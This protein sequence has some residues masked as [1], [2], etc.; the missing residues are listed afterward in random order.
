M[1]LLWTLGYMLSFRISAFVF[2]YIYP[3]MELLGNIVFQFL[4]FWEA[5]ILFSITAALIYNPTNSVW[6][7]PFLQILVNSCYLCS[8]WWYAFWQV[9]GDISLWFWFAFPWWLA[10]LSII[11]C[12]I[13]MLSFVYFL[14]KFFWCW[15]LW[16]V[17]IYWILTPYWS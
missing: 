14:I 6:E 11:S 9:W 7:F 3:G 4:M 17:Y 8:F 10:M 12:A 15:V 13:C 5:S 16:T 1:I 2:L